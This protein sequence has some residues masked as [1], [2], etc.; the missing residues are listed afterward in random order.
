MRPP[1][2]KSFFDCQ[3][4]TTLQVLVS[5]SYT[6][7]EAHVIDASSWPEQAEKLAVAD[8]SVSAAVVR[9]VLMVISLS[10]VLYS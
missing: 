4:L 5:A 9:S 6:V 2:S 7:P 1:S 3:P 8:A 10:P